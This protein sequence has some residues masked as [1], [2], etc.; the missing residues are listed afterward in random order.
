M[1]K[2]APL[3]LLALTPLA[4]ADFWGVKGD[5]GLWRPDYSGSLADGAY[6]LSDIGYGHEDHIYAHLYV[7]HFI[8]LVPN[9]RLS[10]VEGDSERSVNSPMPTNGNA[11]DV[12]TTGV[13]LSHVDITAYYELLDNWVKLDLGLSLRKFDGGVSIATPMGSDSLDM[14]DAIPLLYLQ[15]E[16][17][18]PFT[19]WS[20]GVEGNYT[21][22]DDY[23]VSDYSVRLRYLFDA[24]LDL[25]FEIGY[26]D[27]QVDFSQSFGADISQ[28]GPFAGF[29][30]HF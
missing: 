29:A 12:L 6:H 22:Y 1:K 27:L 7:E 26:R 17:E 19:G 30:F 5:I 16:L 18:L 4:H 15:A 28:G 13:D 24:V 23:E 3:C 2:F 21:E 8:P 11:G 10:I 14:D 9:F 20:L 25:G